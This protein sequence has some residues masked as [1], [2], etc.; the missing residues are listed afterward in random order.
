V[1]SPCVT[2]NDHKGSTKS[3]NYVRE[4]RVELQTIDFV[5]FFDE[6]HLPDEHE[7]GTTREVTLH[8]GSTLRLKK[9]ETE[10]NPSD[11]ML[12]LQTLDE[13]AS[14]GEVLTGVFYVN[15]EKP[16]LIDHLN[17]DETPLHAMNTD[18][19]RPSAAVLAEIM[20]ELS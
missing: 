19:A 2:F 20:D 6:I 12:A 8:D 14:K 4:H 15:T 10:Y 3:Y 16:N 1:I 18:R 13:H 17:L 11:K 5:P 9:I 7:P